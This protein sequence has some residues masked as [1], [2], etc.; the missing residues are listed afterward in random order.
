MTP[1]PML[2]E[3][4]QYMFTH[5][6]VGLCDMCTFRHIYV[7]LVYLYMIINLDACRPTLLKRVLY[8]I[9]VHVD[10]IKHTFMAHVSYYILHMLL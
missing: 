2:H 5:I 6:Q 1:W 10:R 9:E 3:A 7:Q 8:L 4:V